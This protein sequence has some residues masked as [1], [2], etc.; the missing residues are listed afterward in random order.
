MD[1]GAGYRK[2]KEDEIIEKGDEYFDVYDESWFSTKNPGIPNGGYLVYRRKDETVTITISKNAADC[3]EAEFVPSY[4]RG[5]LSAA[6]KAARPIIW[7][8]YGDGI[9]TAEY[10]GRT[11]MILPSKFYGNQFVTLASAEGYLRGK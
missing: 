5:E 9:K 6:V 2:L 4:I 3:L 1:V 10:N 8:D 7:K 11:A